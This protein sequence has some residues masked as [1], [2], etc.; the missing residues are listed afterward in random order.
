MVARKWAMA[1]V[2]EEKRAQL[3]LEMNFFFGT[4][5][6]SEE[7]EGAWRDAQAMSDPVSARTGRT[8]PARH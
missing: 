4:V 1:L 7:Y 3:E 8:T 2:L 6:S 5:L